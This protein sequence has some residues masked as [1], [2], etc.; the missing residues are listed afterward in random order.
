MENL[1]QLE[2]LFTV[3]LLWTSVIIFIVKLQGG[4]EMHFVVA[5]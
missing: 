2:N 3:K 1:M 5:F 4:E